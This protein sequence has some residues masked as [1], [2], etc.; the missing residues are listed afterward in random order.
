MAKLVQRFDKKLKAGP[1][2]KKRS[3]YPLGNPPSLELL[4]TA[5]SVP[6]TQ[7][8]DISVRRNGLATGA[9]V[10][11]WEITDAPATPSSGTLSWASGDAADK[12][13]QFTAGVVTGGAGG[14]IRLSNPR[15]TDGTIGVPAIKVA[16]GSLSITDAIDVAGVINLTSTNIIVDEGLIFQITAERVTN[17][18]GAIAVDYAITG[19][20]TVP[21]NGT[22]TWADG[23]SGIRTATV[24]AGIVSNDV[25]GTVTLS[26]ARRTDGGADQPLLNVA[27]GNLTIKDTPILAKWNL[28]ATISVLAGLSVGVRQYTANADD[29]T[30]AVTSLAAGLNYNSITERIEAAE[31]TA[32][33]GTATFTLSKAGEADVVD[34]ATV[35]LT[36]P[37]IGEA[38]IFV[39]EGGSDLN[40]GTEASP[41]ATLN[42]AISVAVDGDII[43][44][45]AASAGGTWITNQAVVTSKVFSGSNPLTIRVRTGDTVKLH[46]QGARGSIAS[47][48]NISNSRGIIF[49]GSQGELHAGDPSLWST[50][51]GGT[52][53]Y[54]QVTS[55]RSI[56]F[57][58]DITVDGLYF[59]GGTGYPGNE[60]RGPFTGDSAGTNRVVIRNCKFKHHA[61]IDREI[62]DGLQLFGTGNLKIES[63]YFGPYLGG[64]NALA[65][66]SSL[67]PIVVRNNVLEHDWYSATNNGYRA[68]A[69]NPGQAT[70]SGTL[71]YKSSL[72]RQ[73]VEG[74]RIFG[75]TEN[76]SVTYTASFKLF[77]NRL[78]F[79]FNYGW[80]N[81]A[82]YAIIVEYFKTRL[83]HCVEH[84][85]IYHNTFYNDYNI[86][87]F[88]GGGASDGLAGGLL[89]KD[90]RFVNNIWSNITS[91]EHTQGTTIGWDP[92]V[93][94]TIAA[95]RMSN[96]QLQG[97]PDHWLGMI[98]DGNVIHTNNLLRVQLRSGTGTYG[99]VVGAG[100]YVGLPAVKAAWPNVF[101]DS[102][103]DSPAQFVSP[104]VGAEYKEKDD[105]ALLPGSPG[106]G[107]AVPM[108]TVLA[109]SSGTTV[110]MSDAYW[111]YD[112]F[113]WDEEGDWIAFYDSTGTTLKGVR[114]VLSV[115]TQQQATLTEAISVSVDD[116]VFIVPPGEVAAAR[117]RGANQL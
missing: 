23:V 108:A 72:E 22:I 95:R 43:E 41:Y 113:M 114:Q 56:N 31:T 105:F 44:L 79:R 47:V 49:D 115:N 90:H 101:L 37:I 42:K 117:N 75:V 104:P 48:L 24:T 96:L 102:N 66:S 61:N 10:V 28:P 29:W 17:T 57:V 6:E 33:S 77:G 93:E 67:G 107:T 19:V 51:N 13:A 83:A 11:D 16:S 14:T 94:Y 76:Q 111:I 82:P 12:S 53:S 52:D 27:A 58:E 89:G 106:R 9:L 63:N 88:D 2:G 71:D 74:N 36:A 54:P 39:Q 21:L 7:T 81:W 55:I 3:K 1:D 103:E 70:D 20:T 38:T 65:T 110:E 91:V 86:I 18:V 26:N 85:R 112:G 64:H 84:M 116:Q 73:L 34:T 80:R 109:A 40:S 87:T 92:G 8:A 62:G 25:S 78:I 97:Y 60:L 15:W 59:A 5:I 46:P 50:T 35:A 99:S 98:W 100:T 30:I 69:F 45:G 32:A 4:T 68:C